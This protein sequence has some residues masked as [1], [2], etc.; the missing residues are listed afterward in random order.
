[1]DPNYKGI[2]ERKEANFISDSE[3]EA[4]NLTLAAV[5]ATGNEKYY[6]VLGKDKN[7]KSCIVRRHTFLKTVDN[8]DPNFFSSDPKNSYEEVELCKRD[9][10]GFIVEIWVQTVV[11]NTSGVTITCMVGP[12]LYSNICL[13]HNGDEKVFQVALSD[14]LQYIYNC[15]SLSESNNM[16]REFTGIGFSSSNLAPNGVTIAAGA[17]REFFHRVRLPLTNTCL[18]PNH[19]YDQFRIRFYPPNNNVISGTGLT[20]NSTLQLQSLNVFCEWL[21]VKSD[22]YD[23]IYKSLDPISYKTWYALEEPLG[24][25]TC[26]PGVVQDFKIF[27]NKGRTSAGIW[28]I[29]IVPTTNTG[30][31]KMNVDA[32]YDK[33]YFNSDDNRDFTTGNSVYWSVLQNNIINSK[34][35]APC[36]YFNDNSNNPYVICVNPNP[37]GTLLNNEYWGTVLWGNN[38]D[39]TL[40]ILPS[41][42]NTNTVNV[43]LTGIYYSRLIVDP[44]NKTIVEKVL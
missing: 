37:K 5:R 35:F 9:I 30:I 15:L 38:D 26:T 12:C 27:K 8:I 22:H 19:M 11:K 6:T 24:K 10:E 20:D 41:V 3:C 21:Q 28:F 25:F 33:I 2:Y 44:L 17:T 42:G 39:V 23:K 7:N 43:T 34:L 14:N 36:T 40:C 13:S 18:I 32:A 31:N 4:H 1:M 29:T 16:T